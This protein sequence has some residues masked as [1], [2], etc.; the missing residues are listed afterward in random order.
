V[1]ALD[2]LA[3]GPFTPEKRSGQRR[4]VNESDDFLKDRPEFLDACRFLSMQDVEK[5]PQVPGLGSGTRGGSDVIR[6]LRRV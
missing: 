4:V 3:D 6:R 1:Q 2:L 5:T